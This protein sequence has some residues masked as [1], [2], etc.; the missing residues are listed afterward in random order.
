MT[1]RRLEGIRVREMACPWYF[2]LRVRWTPCTLPSYQ[3]IYKLSRVDLFSACPHINTAQT[4][5]PLLPTWHRPP[6]LARA[7]HLMQCSHWRTRCYDPR[8]PEIPLRF[9]PPLKP[10]NPTLAHLVLSHQALSRGNASGKQLRL[11][12]PVVQA[13]SLIHQ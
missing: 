11:L 4:W 5:L 7:P 1:G 10:Y 2:D 9:R 3:L 8:S 6:C 12:H 13:F